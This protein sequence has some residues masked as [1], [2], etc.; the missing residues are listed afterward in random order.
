MSDK[1]F[2]RKLLKELEGHEAAILSLVVSNGRLI[3]GSYDRTMKVWN[4][5][6]GEPVRTVRGH[7]GYIRALTVSGKGKVVSGSDDGTFKVWKLEDGECVSTQ[8]GF[9]SG[10]CALAVNESGTRLFSG[11]YDS[12]II[13]WLVEEDL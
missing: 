11:L 10:V 13:T 9:W 5:E 4:T 3:S 8:S 2:E 12:K 7:S 6:R 1:N